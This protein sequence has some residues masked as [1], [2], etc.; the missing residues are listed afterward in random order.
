MSIDD[1][2]LK[3]SNVYIERRIS[4]AMR[5]FKLIFIF[6]LSNNNILHYFHYVLYNDLS[7]FFYNLFRG[8]LLLSFNKSQ[9][10][11]SSFFLGDSNNNGLRSFL[12]TLSLNLILFMLLLNQRLFFNL[13]RKNQFNRGKTTVCV[14]SAG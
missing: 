1:L 2:I 3:Y 10:V 9:F 4:F 7:S 5:L 12:I 6:I 13:F 11:L 14:A 8:T